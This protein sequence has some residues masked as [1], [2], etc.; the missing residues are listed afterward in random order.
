[1]EQG[2][3]AENSLSGFRNTITGLI[4]QLHTSGKP[5]EFPPANFDETIWT[6]HSRGLR[7]DLQDNWFRIMN[8]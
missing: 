7:G 5:S 8:G 2:G 1:M 4:R 3:P 6:I